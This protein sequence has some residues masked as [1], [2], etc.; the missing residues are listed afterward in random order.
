MFHLW[1]YFF[2]TRVL[3]HERSQGPASFRILGFCP[4]T[5]NLL[6]GGRGKDASFSRTR[7]QINIS[8]T[9]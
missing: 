3:G 5:L 9:L 4:F 6:I 7:A 2:K 8:F 1:A